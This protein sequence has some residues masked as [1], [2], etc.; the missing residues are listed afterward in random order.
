MGRRRKLETLD[1]FQRALKNKYGLGE[2]DCYKPWLRVQD[3]RSIGN[4]AKIQGIKA[5]RE[6]HMLSEHE[7]CFF[8]I[9]EFCDS[10]IDIRE[11][12]PLLPLNLSVKIAKTIGVN[13]PVI[14]N[15]KSL[16]VVTTDFVLTRTDGVKT[17]HEAVSVYA[18]GGLTLSE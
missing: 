16:N 14:P 18:S 11:Q 9:A 15:T 4:S 17:W 12:F 3:V 5:K 6:H 8:Y 7:S 10:I 2:G 1:D 13:H